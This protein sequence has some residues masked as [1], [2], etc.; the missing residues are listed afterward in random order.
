MSGRC[1]CWPRGCRGTPGP[2][3]DPFF[4][5]Y[6]KLHAAGDRDGL[7]RLGLCTWAAAG[8][9]PAAREQIRGAVGAHFSGG[10]HE[11]PDPPAYARLG[12]I[13]APAVVVTGDREY[14]AVARCAA[15]IAARI[16]GC[17]Q[18][19]APGADHLLPLRVPSLIAG[20]IREMADGEGRGTVKV[21]DRLPAG[22]ARLGHVAERGERG[23]SAH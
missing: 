23:R 1:C 18:V 9:N 21:P 15:E 22:T 3:D 4:R 11:R 13:R 10:G 8:D 7:T 16:P 19:P 20:L 12:E 6:G 2:E 14:P 17:G 5:D